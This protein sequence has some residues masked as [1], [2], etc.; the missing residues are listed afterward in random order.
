MRNG[1]SPAHAVRDLRADRRVELTLE[2]GVDL[3]GVAHCRPRAVCGVVAERS[4]AKE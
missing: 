4:S 3:L 2:L 1:A